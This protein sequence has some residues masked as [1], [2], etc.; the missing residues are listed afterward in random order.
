VTEAG[1]GFNELHAEERGLL[2]GLSLLAMDDGVLSHL[3]GN[4]R[5][6]C[7]KAWQ[8]LRALPRPDRAA[9]L[10]GW[11]VEAN[12]PFPGGMERLHPSWL[13]ETVASEPV[14]L[15][16]ALFCA[17]PGAQAVEAL[18]LAFRWEPSEGS[19]TLRPPTP[20][21]TALASLGLA[22][23]SAAGEGARESARGGQGGLSVPKAGGLPTRSHAGA[24]AKDGEA[25]PPESV[26]E[27]QRCAFG[28]LAPFCVGPA[29]PLG[30]GL[31]R[32]GCKELL[33]EVARQGTALRQELCAE[34]DASLWA[35]AGRLPATLGRQWVK[36]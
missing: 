9:L 21:P 22:R 17:L 11:I 3:A 31:C 23:W 16:P 32:L 35:V 33:A 30:A 14:E 4:R 27:L 19:Q 1:F 10:A 36:W 15:W 7:G 2:L 6:V 5:Q 34:G 12:G 20:T 28:R 26:F 8:A 24:I 29:G 13:A 18:L 25:W